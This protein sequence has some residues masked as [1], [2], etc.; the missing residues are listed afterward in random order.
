MLKSDTLDLL[1]DDLSACGSEAITRAFGLSSYLKA[2]AEAAKRK[3]PRAVQHWRV[4]AER[5]AIPTLA[6]AAGIHASRAAVCS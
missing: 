4:V 2:A 6:P 5:P 3:D 1:W